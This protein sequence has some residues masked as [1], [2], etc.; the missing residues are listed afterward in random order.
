ML[1]TQDIRFGDTAMFTPGEHAG[2]VLVRLKRPGRRALLAKILVAECGKASENL[3]LA[4]SF[5]ETRED[6]PQRDSRAADRRFATADLWVANDVIVVVHH[7]SFRIAS[8]R[9]GGGAAPTGS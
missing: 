9:P 1:I 8:R 5:R 6:R 7:R 4:A 2:F 3:V